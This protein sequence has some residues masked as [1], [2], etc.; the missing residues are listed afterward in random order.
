MLHQN[1]LP[2]Q[3]PLAVNREKLEALEKQF[4]RKR[5]INKTPP[6]KLNTWDQIAKLA[7]QKPQ[8]WI[9]P[10][11]GTLEYCL[12]EHCG[13][14]SESEVQADEALHKERSERARRTSH[15]PKNWGFDDELRYEQPI[16]T[17]EYIPEMNMM[18]IKDRNLND[19]ARRIALFIVRHAYQDNRKE[20]TLGTTVSFIMK[21][22]TLSRRTVQRGLALLAKAGYI[23]RF[24]AASNKTRM[25]RG[26]LIKLLSPLFPKHFKKEWPETLRFSAASPLT[27]NHRFQIYIKESFFFFSEFEW[28][29]RCRDGVLRSHLRHNPL[30]EIKLTV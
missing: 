24:V 15:R 1:V 9:K 8:Y 10:K 20:R 28:M 12:A 3:T 7:G 19:S 25:C 22:L 27:H 26:L 30:S 2:P 21:G 5:V 23:E 18:F 11:F 13:W 29:E 6:E 17:E 14:I 16:E 4:A